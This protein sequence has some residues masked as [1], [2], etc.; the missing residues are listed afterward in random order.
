MF[1]SMHSPPYRSSPPSPPVPDMC[2]VGLIVS[3]TRHPEGLVIIH[4]VPGGAAHRSGMVQVG[5][6]LVGIDGVP[7]A[8][9]SLKTV[10]DMILGPSGTQ[11]TL[12]LRD[13]NTGETMS[14]SLVRDAV[15]TERALT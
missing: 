4:V 1:H 6:L 2:G 3:G 5:R 7:V 8:H 11:L 14:V 9:A 12:T 15:R 10:Q 13:L